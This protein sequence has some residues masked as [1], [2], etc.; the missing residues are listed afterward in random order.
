MTLIG[1][2]GAGKSTI[3]NTLPGCSADQGEI[4]YQGADLARLNAH[5]VVKLGWRWSLRAA[6]LAT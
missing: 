6:H 4:V 5:D 2:N 3:L 1:A